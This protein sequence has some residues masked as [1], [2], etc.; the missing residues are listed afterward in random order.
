[1]FRSDLKKAI[2]ISDNYVQTD[3]LIDN[4][5]KFRREGDE[6]VF[7]IKHGEYIFRDVEKEINERKKGMIK[8]DWR[9]QD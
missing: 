1:M 2:I 3:R 8:R 5:N 9:P 4:P 6:K 7:L